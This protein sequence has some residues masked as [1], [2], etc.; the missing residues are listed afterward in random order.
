MPAPERILK[1][2][3]MEKKPEREFNIHIRLNPKRLF[4]GLFLIVLLVG[5]FFVGRFT[6]EP[7]STGT[8]E[9]SSFSLGRIFSGIGTGSS[10]DSPTGAIVQETGASS[11]SETA[12]PEGTAA[13]ANEGAETAGSE[14]TGSAEETSAG[15]ASEENADDA[16]DSDADAGE[17]A[18]DEPIIT[19]Y[20]KV[21]VSLSGLQREVKEA[22]V[23]G[24]IT[25]IT[26][27]IKNNEEGTVKPGYLIM[28]VE[29]YNEEGDKRRITP[30][31]ET[32]TIRA[33]QSVS[34]TVAVPPN[35]FSYH[36][37]S[38]GKLDSV[39]ITIILFDEN[40]KAMATFGKEFNLN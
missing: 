5:A 22:D 15:V 40:S 39:F 1:E 11:G 6:A 10:G 7:E 13:D 4:K 30:A 2:E 8:Q 38:A 36:R 24:K 32:T 35:G 31:S 37:S 3:R 27:T 14:S 19:T 28:R 29:G 34:A 25:K 12:D 20:T 16:A 18:S 21:A 17:T 9:T 23:W 26:Y 33:G